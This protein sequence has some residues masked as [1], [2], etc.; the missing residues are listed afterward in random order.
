MFEIYISPSNQPRN[1]YAYG[2]TNEKVQMERVARHM[3]QLLSAYNCT[4]ILAT[5]SLPYT[6][7][8]EE[9]QA[10][11]AKLY[12]AIHSDAGPVSAIGA[13]AFY[14]PATS[15]VAEKAIT[16]LNRICP[17]P[18]NRADQT[19]DGLAAG[20]GEIWGPKSK[21]IPVILV[22]VNFHTNPQ[23][24]KWIIE[25]TWEIAQAQVT[26][27][28][29]QYGLTL[30]QVAAP[31]VNPTGSFQII[32]AVPELNYRVS[33]PINGV[34]QPIRGKIYPPTIYTIVETKNGWGRL[35]SG[36]G[37]INISSKYVKRV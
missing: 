4:P 8:D 15:A 32:A 36:A 10:K 2:G 13:T 6:S 22:E 27:I 1:I 23:V 37:W 7:R 16:E 21:G 3:V 17:Y 35:K 20:F 25:N 34:L 33:P 29:A 12:W 24:A 9:A 14:T 19:K 11:G 5:L 30:K 31:Q 26:A 18:E 28:V